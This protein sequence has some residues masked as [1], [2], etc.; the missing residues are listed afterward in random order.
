MTKQKNVL[1]IWVVIS[2]LLFGVTLFADVPELIDYQGRL[3]DDNSD[4]VNGSVSIEFNI[5]DV[6]SG[7]V[8]LWTETQTVD[9]SDGLFQVT[10]GDVTALDLTFENDSHWLGINVAADGEMIPRTRIT[11]TAYAINAGDVK[12]HDIHPTSVSIDGYGAVVN[13]SGEWTGEGIPVTGDLDLGY[14]SNIQFG[15]F[16]TRIDD[17]GDDMYVYTVNDLFLRATEVDVSQDMEVHSTLTA[18]EF[19]GDGSGLTNVPGDDLGDHSATQNVRLLGNWLSGDGGNEGIHVSYAGSVGIGTSSPSAKLDVAGGAEINGDLSVAN[20]IEFNESSKIVFGDTSTRIQDN[21]DDL[22]LFSED[23]LYYNSNNHNFTGDMDVNGGIVADSFSGDGSALTG[24][25]GDDLGDHTATQNVKL[26]GNWLSNDGGNEGV[27]VATDGDVGIGTAS[28]GAVLDVSGSG[29]YGLRVTETSGADTKFEIEPYGEMTLSYGTNEHVRIGS[30]AGPAGFVQLTDVGV[31]RVRISGDEGTDS[32]FN[33]GDVGIGTMTPSTDLEVNGTISTTDLGIGTTTPEFKLSLDDDGGILAKGQYN[34]G[35]NLTTT[36]A[37]TRMFWYPR[38]AAFRAGRV[39]GDDWNNSNIGMYSA[40]FGYN[41]YA[42]G[43]YSFAGGYNTEAGGN[44]STAFGHTSTANGS[45]AVSIGQENTAGGDGAVAL[46]LECDA[47]A[48]SSVAIGGYSES[49]GTGSVALG[50]YATVGTGDDGSVAIGQTV[51]VDS[52]YS[53]GLGKDISVT[54]S[55]SVGIG[56]DITVSANYATSLGFSCN[57]TRNHSRT[58]GSWCDA[59]GDLSI[60]MGNNTETSSFNSFVLGRY[61]VGGGTNASWIGTESLFEIGNGSSDAAR[62]NAMTVLKNG[63]VGIGVD[64]PDEL[65]HVEGGKFKIGTGETIE[66]G[67]SYEIAFNAD[68]RPTVDN[69]LDLGTSDERWDDVYATNGT[70]N[71]SDRRDKENIRNTKYGLKEIMQMRP[72]SFNWRDNPNQGKKL[73][74]IAQ[75]LE[76]IVPEV[77]KTHD[78]K[79]IDEET[80]R[81]EKVELERLGV[82]YS[83][84]IPVLIKAIQEQQKTIEELKTE[85]DALKRK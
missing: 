84:L 13:A 36:G 25:S 16:D 12:G 79:I 24:V 48:S 9:V 19:V 14:N 10:L 26:D 2:L 66:D 37:G 4:P 59:N 60:A 31:T 80:G 46:G 50:Y 21:A 54:G 85:V 73:G 69:T 70:I 58:F 15:D 76:E 57:A 64:D 34:T 5:Y 23:D 38:K 81:K 3:T 52:D 32:Y 8:A 35:T 28:P 51:S 78:Y 53:V 55:N 30:D 42:Y 7:G 11:S 82:Y 74:L 39:T 18:Y 61:N 71:T 68:L 29:T 67:G 63:K 49:R 41:A 6:D 33:A 43:T 72:V 45:A 65:L 77:V 17:N 47:T 44:Y 27:F 62:S 83:D 1:W 56:E 22:Y 75:E 40:G 20:D